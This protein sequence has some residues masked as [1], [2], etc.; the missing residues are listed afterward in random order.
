MNSM[1]A[2]RGIFHKTFSPSTRSTE[3]SLKTSQA[4]FP[5]TKNSRDRD[6]VGWILH[7][8]SSIGEGR[9]YPPARCHQGGPANGSRPGSQARGHTN[10]ISAK[11]TTGDKLK[12]NLLL[13]M[14]FAL[15]ASGMIWLFCVWRVRQRKFPNQRWVSFISLLHLPRSC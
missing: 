14:V 5:R 4:N 12:G 3:S 2:T 15:A 1:P 9:I 8:R 13:H 7:G 11:L 10:A 6:A